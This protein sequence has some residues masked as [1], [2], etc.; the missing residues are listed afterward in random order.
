MCLA[1]IFKEKGCERKILCKN[2]ARLEFVQDEII[3]TD[4][5]M[6]TTIL[7]EKVKMIDLVEGII[8]LEPDAS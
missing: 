2:I 3:V 4:V 6:R 5:L 7:T 8:I 1:T